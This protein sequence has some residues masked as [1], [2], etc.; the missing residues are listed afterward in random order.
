MTDQFYLKI[1]CF[2]YGIQRE[3]TDQEIDRILKLDSLIYRKMV[4]LLLAGSFLEGMD[5]TNFLPFAVIIALLV[6][7]YYQD[8]LVRELQLD[9][10]LVAREQ[11]KE[12]RKF[13]IRKTLQDTFKSSL[14]ALA[15]CIMIWMMNIPQGSGTTFD[16]FWKIS[17]P[18][19]VLLMTVIVLPINYIANRKKII[20]TE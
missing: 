10:M 8:K 9:K 18:G 13:M 2:L 3:L 11:L 6:P 4:L 5:F 17:V 19:T 1:F 12:A 15:T 16:T 7:L 20:L 14:L